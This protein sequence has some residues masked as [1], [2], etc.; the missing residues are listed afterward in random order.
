[1]DD[2]EGDPSE[3][4]EDFEEE[5][6]EEDLFDEEDSNEFSDEFEEGEDVESDESEEDGEEDEDEEPDITSFSTTREIFKS[7]LFTAEER[8]REYQRRGKS[9]SGVI[10]GEYNDT[11]LEDGAMYNDSERDW[12]ADA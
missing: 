10:D 5:E 4:N 2:Y 3:D 8:R 11:Y 9:P 7:G 12:D 6:V 1:M